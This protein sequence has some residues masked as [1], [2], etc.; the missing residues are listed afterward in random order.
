MYLSRR[1]SEDDN[2]ESETFTDFAVTL[3]KLYDEEVKPLNYFL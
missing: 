3:N 2:S 1:I